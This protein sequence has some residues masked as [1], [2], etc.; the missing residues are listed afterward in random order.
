[1]KNR[2]SINS[3]AGALILEEKDGCIARLEFGRRPEEGEK[4]PVLCEA[5]RQLEAY[6]DGKLREF[7]LPLAPQ[8]TPFQLAVWQALMEIPYGQT[9]SYKEIAMAVGREKA[10]RAVGM[11]NNRNPISIIVPCHRVVGADGSLVGYGGGLEVKKYLL[12][13]EGVRIPE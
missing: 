1:M 2:I 6:F 13:L 3:P 11:A 8:G 10:C 4:T 7:D 12:R 9:R 5:V